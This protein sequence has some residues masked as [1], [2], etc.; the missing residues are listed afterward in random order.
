MSKETQ[1][2]QN[3]LSWIFGMQALCPLVVSTGPLA[4][5]IYIIVIE[6]TAFWSMI[7]MITGFSWIPFV[8][9]TVTL[10]FV[11]EFRQRIMFFKNLNSSVAPLNKAAKP[12]AIV[13]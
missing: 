2:L 5:L 6:G 7:F 13:L 3:Q 8:N 10:C 4:Y 12:V 9:A 1:K 11:G